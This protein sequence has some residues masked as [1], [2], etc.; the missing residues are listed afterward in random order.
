[1]NTAEQLESELCRFV[2][3]TGVGYWEY[4][5]VRDRLSFSPL[6]RDWLGG[7]FPAPEGSSLNDW[8]ARIHP[9]DLDSAKAAVLATLDSGAMFAVEYRFARADGSWLWLLSRGQISNRDAAGRPLL[10]RGTKADI[11][12]RKL[13]EEL[14]LLQQRFNQIL[15]DSPDRETLIAAV[16]DT[17]LSLSV[18]DGGGLYQVREDG[19]YRLIESHGISPEFVGLASEIEPDTPRARIL[20]SG[21]HV[22]TCVEP[23]STCTHPELIQLPHIRQEGITTLLVLPIQVNGLTYASLNLFSRH[24]RKMP[25]N[26]ANF[27]EGLA[28]Q[29]GQAL[30]RLQAREDAHQQRKNLDGFFQAISDFVF[31]LDIDG[32][33]QY[34][35][36]AVMSDLGYDESLLGQSVLSVHPPR[37]HAEA[38]RVVGQMLAGERDSCPLPLLR[39]DGSEIMVDTRIVHGSWNGKPALLGISRDI[40]ASIQAAQALERERGFLKTLVQTIP[41][42]IWLKDPQGVY[43]A[44]NPR[45]EQLYG[46]PEA[47]IV[48]K[49]DY[50]FVDRETADFFRAN[51]LSAV[52]AGHSRRNEERLEFADGSP[53]GLFETTKTPM[54]AADGSL[55]GVLG[56][57]H[58]ITAMR[59]YENALNEAS[60]RRRQMMDISRDS[61]AIIDQEHRIIEANQR[62]AEMLGYSMPEL[63]KLHTW[64]WEANLSEADIRKQ[65]ADLKNINATFETM[66]RRKDSSCYEAEVSATGTNF[67]GTGVVITVSRDISKRKADERALRESEAALSQAQ[68]VARIGSWRLDIERERLS[69]SDETYRIFGI[70]IGVPIALETFVDC[71]HPDDRT[72][73]LSAWNAALTG[74]PYDIE[75][76][77]LVNREVQWVR[78]RAQVSFAEGRPLYAVGTV[79]HITEQKQ[80]QIRLARSEERYRILADYSTDWQYWLGPE[81]RYL[82]VSPGCESITGYPP[83]AF[84]ED[85]EL[86]GSIMHPDDRQIWEKHWVAISVGQHKNPHANLEFRIRTRQGGTRWI[87]HQCQPV[88][89]GTTDYQGR[90]GV[91]R[92][93]TE[94]K[95]AEIALRMERD[96]SQSYLDTI[97]AVIVALDGVGRITLINRK[98]CDL[99]GYA[100]DELL[101]CNWFERCLPQP[102]GMLE[103]FPV[104][105]AIIGGH[106]EQAEYFEN[107]VVTRSGSHRLIAW[108]NSL[109][110]DPDGSITGSL[111]A[112]EDVTERRVAERALSESSLFL[113]ESQRIARVGGWKANPDTDMLVW[114]DEVYR[115]CEHPREQPP[116]LRE[117]L[118]YYAPE[119]HPQIQAALQAAWNEGQPFTMETQMLL[120][121]G[122]RF[123]AELR[124]IGRVDEPDGS[125]LA[126]T[127]QDITDRKAIHDELEQHRQHLEALVAQRTSEVVA[128][129]ERA[130]AAN[131]AKST[132]LANMSH[133]IRTPMNAI[134]GLTHL[135]RNATHDARQVDHLDKINQAARHLLGIINDILDISKIE[136]GKMSLE[137]AD[138]SVQQVISNTLDLIRDK[139]SAKH[140]VL[141]SEIDPALPRTMRGDALRLGQVLLNFAGNAVKFTERGYIRVAV[142]QVMDGD[143][144]LQVRFEV[145]DS[146]IGMDAEQVERLFQ[147]FEQADTSTTRKYGGT[148][149]GLAISK[150]LV[151]LMGADGIF[152]DSQPG[153]GSRFWFQ[154]P[155]LAGQEQAAAAEQPID[156]RAALANRRGA[157]ILLAEDNMV[158]QEVAL[159][160]LEEAGLRADVA[161]NG[162]EALQLVQ[163]TAY[164]LVLMDVQMPVMDGYAATRAIRALRGRERTPILAMTANA[165]DEDR[166][167]CMLAG[168][169]DHVAKPVDPDVL[170]AALI[171]WLPAQG[172]GHIPDNA[173]VAALPT[174]GDALFAALAGIPGLDVAAGLHNLRGNQSSYLRLLQVYIESHRT[175]MAWLRERLEAGEREDARRIAH[176]LKGASGAL[177]AATVQSLAAELEVLLRNDAAPTEVESLSLRVESA[178]GQ[179]AALLLGVLPGTAAKSEAAQPAMRETGI[180][181]DKLEQLLRADD[182][183]AGDAL[184]DALPALGRILPAAKLAELSRQIETYQ[185]EVALASLRTARQ[186]GET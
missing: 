123:W 152:V 75:H 63:L 65:F 155:L 40:S 52:A 54:L 35:N 95:Q 98:G 157:R 49:T 164:D 97:E 31:V 110:R 85:P 19:G 86:M 159:A 120:R 177:G 8:F 142:R 178:Q 70:P 101:G 165:F 72:D 185:F 140:L 125:Y 22:C 107:A 76:R 163:D 43:L 136:A 11:G 39:A 112:G 79:Q 18:L 28:D 37:V 21:E 48:G 153:Q 59:A 141:S 161:A 34:V 173:A 186:L 3:S 183:A 166:R 5:L 32:R 15:L 115:L 53:G 51:D 156:V 14:F 111:S 176:S 13:Q 27:L 94:R 88:T 4:D 116:G 143:A 45:F 180:L 144:G 83:Q 38:M 96:R 154:I 133:E 160:L 55:I 137:I 60:E 58:D 135:L 109:I 20:D 172:G 33:I 132:F 57:A 81:G 42:L 64:D 131:R 29:F 61:I 147:A 179:L 62:F 181:L 171:K 74:D 119:F 9:D 44:C 71:I 66:H 67:D 174:N 124:C 100:A 118:A 24:L 175:D 106:I 105:Q 148:G 47:E 68:Q 69:W 151:S 7:D 162:A 149:L 128:E 25:E 169:D 113:R 16:L 146:G 103:V 126:G 114:T 134:I 90:R 17:V 92:D 89:T 87:E 23:A 168:M 184:R 145:I 167:Q 73:V 36:P 108:H 102:T 50:E 127:F 117:G 41:D 26:V 170:Y 84:I 138:F 6:L 1:M 104:F 182:M 139:A 30:E 130:E 10:C 12:E 99:L 93:I 129:R 2:E 78:E 56:I 77:I 91:N 122:R 82:Y 150:H 46:K 158:N 121:S 80:A